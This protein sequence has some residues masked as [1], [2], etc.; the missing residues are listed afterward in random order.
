MDPRDALPTPYF[1]VFVD[2]VFF[3]QWIDSMLYIPPL[4]GSLSLAAHSAM[5]PKSNLLMILFVVLV[6]LF[7]LAVKVPSGPESKSV[8]RLSRR[9]LDLVPVPVRQEEA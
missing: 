1:V 3:F 5:R 2:D 4:H 8:T 9:S 6:V 7:C